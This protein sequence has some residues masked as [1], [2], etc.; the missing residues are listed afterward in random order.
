VVQSGFLSALSAL[1]GELGGKLNTSESQS[2]RVW[3]LHHYRN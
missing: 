3:K 2:A 1:R